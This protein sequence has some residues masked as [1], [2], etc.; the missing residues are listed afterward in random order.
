MRSSLLLLLILSAGFLTGTKG[1]LPFL[2]NRIV[3]NILLFSIFLLIFSMGFKIGSEPG[4]IDKLSKIG[5]FSLLFAMFTI[6]GTIVVLISLFLLIPRRQLMNASSLESTNKNQ[7]KNSKK[8]IK[9]PVIFLSLLI[10]GFATGYILKEFGHVKT[11]DITVW[12]LYIL[13]FFIGIKLRRE[14]IKLSTFIS[15]ANVWIVPMGTVTGSLL[16]GMVLTFILKMRIGSG[17]SVSAGFGWYSL[18]GVLLS[19]LDGPALGSIAF[20]SNMFRETTAL[21][22]IPVFRRTRFPLTAVGI[23]GATSMDVTLPVIVK[24]YGSSFAPISIASGIIV[25]FFVPLL[26]PLLYQIG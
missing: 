2:K 9:D 8:P 22:L 14:E 6:A 3:E 7:T 24:N 4:I 25:S 13:V 21:I 20:L 18:S 11:G 12:I 1:I 26:V 23:A 5:L 15:S 16:G 19:K 10:A 17:L